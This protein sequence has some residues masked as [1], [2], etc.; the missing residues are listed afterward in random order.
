[1]SELQKIEQLIAKKRDELRPAGDKAREIQAEREKL[2]TE[3][4]ALQ[5]QP[6]RL[7]ELIEKQEEIAKLTQTLLWM[8]P[9][10]DAAQKEI[11]ELGVR[12][13]RIVE[14]IKM[15][16]ARLEKARRSLERCQ[17]NHNQAGIREAEKNIVNCQTRLRQ[18]D[19][20]IN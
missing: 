6:S 9:A 19:T 2:E 17:R 15:E 14:F 11:V 10:T 12:R 20:N 13:D 16:K 4:L 18:L 7:V 8:R 1:M 3:V 5:K